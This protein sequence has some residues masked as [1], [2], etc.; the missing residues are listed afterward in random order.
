MLNLPFKLHFKIYVVYF[1]ISECFLFKVISFHFLTL[2]QIVFQ[3][4]VCWRL[5]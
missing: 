3:S 4:K 1:F 5:V 2:K